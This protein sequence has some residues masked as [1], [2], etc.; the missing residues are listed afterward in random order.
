MTKKELKKKVKKLEEQ[1]REQDYRWEMLKDYLRV[2]E[3]EY[4][5]L[6]S[7][8]S[9][10]LTWGLFEEKVPVKKRKLVKKGKKHKNN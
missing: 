10:S 1:L 4:A 6:E 3:E 2:K 8:Y 5:E 7:T 9:G